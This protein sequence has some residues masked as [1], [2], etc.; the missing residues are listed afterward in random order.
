[1]S[2]VAIYRDGGKY[3]ITTDNKDKP[4]DYKIGEDLTLNC[5]YSDRMSPAGNK[6][7]H[8]ILIV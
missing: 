2:V 1:M 6:G 4:L 7:N 3:S 8:K 5:D